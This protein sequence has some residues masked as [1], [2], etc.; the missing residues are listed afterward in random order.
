MAVC[1]GSL[2]LHIYVLLFLEV[3]EL[4]LFLKQFK[5]CTKKDKIFGSKDEGVKRKSSPHLVLVHLGFNPTHFTH[6]LI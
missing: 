3:R 2:T 5:K 6:F 4:I 1:K